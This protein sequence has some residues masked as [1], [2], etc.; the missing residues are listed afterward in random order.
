MGHFS[1]GE[2]SACVKRHKHSPPKAHKNSSTTT[3]ISP[4]AH[5]TKRRTTPSH[6]KREHT[7]VL[8]RTGNPD[9]RRQGKGTAHLRG[10]LSQAARGHVGRRDGYPPSGTRSTRHRRLR[11]KRPGGR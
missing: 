6:E 11:G 1:T 2:R 4:F 9:L 5:P 10:N 7:Q 3:R 8:Q